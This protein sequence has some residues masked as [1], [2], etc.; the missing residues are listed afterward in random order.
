MN[1][2]LVDALGVHKIEH[3]AFDPTAGADVREGIPENK[4]RH[5]VE[6][7]VRVELGVVGFLD[8]VGLSEGIFPTERED[9]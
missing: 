7:V 1:P 3:L 5:E 6:P 2:H 8:T 9:V 4:V